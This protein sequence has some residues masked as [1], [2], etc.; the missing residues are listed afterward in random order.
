M[1]VIPPP[2]L[3][4]QPNSSILKI[5][6]Q[7]QQRQQQ[8]QQQ[9]QRTTASKF[10]PANNS[11][12]RFLNT[13]ELINNCSNAASRCFDCAAATTV[14]RLYEYNERSTW[15]THR[16]GRSENSSPFRCSAV[17]FH[18]VALVG[19]YN[20]QRMIKSIYN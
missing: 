1:T 17:N 13:F 12:H 16:W 8:Q 19:L 11:T 5:Q 6:H 2:I 14:L 10:D 15:C 4:T 7:Q 3:R 9:P 20:V 18:L